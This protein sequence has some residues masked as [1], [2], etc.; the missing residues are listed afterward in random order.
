MTNKSFLLTSLMFLVLTASSEISYAQLSH[1]FTFSRTQGFST[2]SSSSSVAQSVSRVL[3]YD[4]KSHVQKFYREQGQQNWKDQGCVTQPE[5]VIALPSQPGQLDQ[6]QI[7]DKSRQFGV[8][9]RSVAS[10]SRLSKRQ[11]SMTGFSGSGYSVFVQPQ[12]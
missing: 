10:H 7:I 4:C 5:N 8:A 6:F 3:G 12:N 1:G 9:D 11:K 2:N